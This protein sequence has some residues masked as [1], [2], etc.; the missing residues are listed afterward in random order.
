MASRY[1]QPMEAPR[2]CAFYRTKAGVAVAPLAALPDGDA[3][4]SLRADGVLWLL[5]PA[6]FAPFHAEHLTRADTGERCPQMLRQ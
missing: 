6:P 2:L 4:S 1:P 3:R 5:L